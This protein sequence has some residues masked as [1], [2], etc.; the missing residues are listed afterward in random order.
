MIEDCFERPLTWQRTDLAE[1]PFTVPVAGGTWL[2]RINDFPVEPLYTLMID[3]QEI[4]DF[5]DWPRCW[6]RPE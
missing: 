2:I 5:D 4:A 6:G 1:F 3:G